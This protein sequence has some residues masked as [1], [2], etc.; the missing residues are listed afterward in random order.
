[1]LR[2]NP[3]K[4]AFGDGPVGD[5]LVIKVEPSSMELKPL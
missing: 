2:P 1:M 3:H 4:M 5:D